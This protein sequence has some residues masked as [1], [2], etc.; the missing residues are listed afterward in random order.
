MSTARASPSRL[1]LARSHRLPILTQDAS[2][3]HT[4]PTQPLR[5]SPCLVASLLRFQSATAVLLHSVLLAAAPLCSSH[6]MRATRQAPR[7][8]T[9][10]LSV[11]STHCFFPWLPTGGP[12]QQRPS[13]ASMAPPHPLASLLRGNIS[14]G[15]THT[16]PCRAACVPC[17]FP[18]LYP[19]QHCR[20]TVFAHPP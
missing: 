18:C 15:G 6:L 13:H 9:T 12:K 11:H 8:G 4:S 2:A 17:L 19:A 14:A 16:C 5:F 7:L 10:P 3:P 20:P 1:L